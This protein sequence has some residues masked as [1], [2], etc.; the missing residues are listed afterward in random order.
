M[1]EP[2]FSVAAF[3]SDKLATPS[4]PN[5]Y[6][7][8]AATSA[9]LVVLGLSDGSLSLYDVFGNRLDHHNSL[10]V[11]PIVALALG[12]G[13]AADEVVA[14][15]GGARADIRAARLFTGTSVTSNISTDKSM[16]KD[17]TVAFTRHIET[18]VV[19]LAVDP[20]FGKP[21]HG[22]RVAYA[23]ASGRVAL[24]T[25][26]WFGGSDIPIEHSLPE[27]ASSLSWVQHLLAYAISDS[28]RVYDTRSAVPVCR[29]ASPGSSAP[30][31]PLPKFRQHVLPNQPH[32]NINNN[33]LTP[34]AHTLKPSHTT[35]QEKQPSIPRLTAAKTWALKTK[36]FM[37]QNLS[38]P[39]SPHGES[40]VKLYVTW[41][42]GARIVRIGPYKDVLQPSD[43]SQ[44][45]PVRDIAVEFRLNRETL[46]MTDLSPEELNV[47]EHSVNNMAVDSPLL[48]LVPFGEE[49]TVALI[50]TPSK[51]LMIHLIT[52]EGKSEKSMR[53]THKNLCD[54][55]MHTIPGGDPLVLIFGHLCSS[56]QSLKT[57]DDGRGPPKQEVVYVRSRTTAER[58]KWLLGQ[59]RFSDA[60]EVAQSAPGG[61]LRRAEVSLEDVG[62]QFLES[63]RE[64]G[65]YDRLASVLPETITTTTPYFGFRARDKIM[66]KRKKRWERWI[67]TF[68]KGHK[69]EI[70]APVIP[71]YEPHL[72]EDTYNS[73]LSELCESVPEVMLHVLKTW[74]ADVYGVSA[75]TIAIEEKLAGMEKHS[76]YSQEGREALREGL[77]MMYGLSGRHDETLNLLL[78]EE[79]PKVYD[80]IRS[81]HLF[82][83]VRSP[84]TIQGLY[85]IDASAATDVLSHA[86]ETVLPPEA[87]VPI[88]VKLDK[89][90]W[91][92]MYL[93]A[94]FR[95]DPEQAPKYHNQ[96][97]K[98]Y[99]QHGSPGLLFNFLRTSSHYSLDRALEEMGGPKGFKPGQLA[100]ERVYVLSTMGD[101]NSS[102]DIL[103]SELG[104]TFAAIEFAS[105]HGDAILWERLI[106][107]AKT[108][109]DT[110]A[111]LLD[112]PAGGKVDP[113]RLVPLLNSE[114]RIP[115]LRDRLHRILVDAALERALREDAAAALHH[116]ASELLNTLDECVSVLP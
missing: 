39:L 41:P 91:T 8:C 53:L 33:E 74:P 101:L 87:V 107:H 51:G 37:E 69:L 44:R 23:D 86:P 95:L 12:G 9:K 2:S 10:H 4:S 62:E 30:P 18:D 102:M 96:L 3:A 99:V 83:A 85:K 105:D 116:D 49:D 112:S 28:V 104:D 50:G 103:L 60:L 55:D 35:E 48:A 111:A 70:V 88:L 80:Y 26:G 75:V 7:T 71:T 106:E 58:V 13:P 19:A 82:E 21:R 14:S 79:S 5:V 114:M 47:M 110:L 84:E 109:A 65:E 76:Q 54:A 56:K 20:N 92:F 67:E 43:P 73:I 36:I 15:A 57:T 61:S 97:L 22:D 16:L 31:S 17:A 100:R 38:E 52:P 94:V 29:V 27:P 90:E 64:K 46:P 11:G 72:D 98:L 68:K 89:S 24:Y 34:P 113:V 66:A 115:H 32:E 42:T 6:V 63:L 25:A 81:H 77:L 1:Q 45:V 59:N 108:H 78:R 40:S 93:H